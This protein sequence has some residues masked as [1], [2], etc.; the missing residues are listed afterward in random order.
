MKKIISILLLLTLCIGIFAGCAPAE[1]PA[2]DA[3]AEYLYAMYKDAKS[4]TDADYTV[5]SQV[6]V[7]GVVYP[8]TWTTDK[9]ENAQVAGSENNMTTIKIVAAEEDI[10]YKL[11]ATLKNEQGQ[12]VSVSF[13]RIIP[14]KAQVSGKTFVLA[15]PKENKFITGSHYLYTGK[16]KWQLN[17]TDNEAEAIALEVIE[18]DDGTVTFKAGDNYLFCDATH[19]KFVDAQDDNTKFV[20][21]AADTDGGYYIK[22]AYANYNGKAQYLE[23][24]SGYLTCYSMGT[25]PS[26]YVFKLQETT[27]A[28]G[29]IS[30]LEGSSEPEETEPAAT[31]P[32]ATEPAATEAPVT[33]EKVVLSFP[34]EN[35]FVTGS[36]SLYEAKNKWQLNITDNKADAIALEKITN[37]DGTVTFKAGNQYLFCDG[38]HVKFV[39]AQDDNTKF[40]LEA[41]DGG[42][43]IKCAVANYNG[44]P[45]YLEVYYG[46]LTC[47]GM[48]TDPSIYVFTLENA[49]G[50]KGTI[51]GLEETTEPE[52]TNPPATE[53]PTT[54]AGDTLVFDFSG[55]TEMGK[56]IAAE[57]ALALFNSVASSSGLTA[58]E[59][60]KIYNGNSTGGAH[61]DSTGFIRCGKSDVDGEL[62]L[63]FDKKVAAVEILCHD[64]YSKSDNY[65][66]NNNQV[67]I[68]GSN[69]QL[70]PYNETGAAAS[71]VFN[72]DG[73]S[74]VVDFDFTNTQ[75]GKT[76][77]VF[78]FKMIIT[79]AE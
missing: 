2:L 14:A 4:T 33:S 34:K 62:V 46:V 32:V 57:D 42:Y 1:D 56:E 43:Y 76:G 71:M 49:D 55:L 78:I 37:S 15:Y 53:A 8:I 59:L 47:Y 24:Y 51:S 63:T 67:A 64:W 70:A 36:H 30:G 38:T 40:V 22:C 48:G 60:T 65:P 9:A 29:T 11:T 18:N 6:R 16:N 23:V 79:F 52:A 41:A 69:A 77:R 21:E 3:A 54:P 72:L 44:N 75:S 5:V 73:S 66:T 25:D 20:L 10:N 26:I 61:P 68:N 28:A 50:A 31:E 17:L 13:D 45:Q 7:D 39:D 12:E 74:N 19:V 27:V 58:I 35:K